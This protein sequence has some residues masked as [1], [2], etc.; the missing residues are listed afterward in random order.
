MPSPLRSLALAGMITLSSGLL[1]VPPAAEIKRVF[2]ALDTS[3]N[4][5]IGLAEWEQASFALFKSADT[6]RDNFLSRDE[7]APGAVSL[8]TFLT[9]DSN[10]D[11]KLSIGEFMTLRRA[12]FRAADL[13]GDDFLEINE[14]EIF[15]LLAQV[16]WN[17]RN[18]NGR[19]DPNELKA[20][21]TLAFEQLD[22]DKNGALDAVEGAFLSPT[23]RAEMEKSGGGRVTLESFIAGYFRLLTG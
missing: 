15:H 10:Q 4:D 20:A 6:N 21:L 11:G 18:K 23:H 13:N 17:D 9:A 5:A 19:L 1:A 3:Q 16:G 8:E 12:I 7:I 22:T 14:Y 2:D